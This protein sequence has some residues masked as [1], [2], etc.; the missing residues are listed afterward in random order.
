[1]GKNVRIKQILYGIAAS[2]VLVVLCWMSSNGKNEEK[3]TYFM[4]CFGDSILGQ[5]RNEYGVV[6][7]LE[8]K[9]QKSVFNGAFGGSHMSR[10]NSA[11]ELANMQDSLSMVALAEAIA[12][13]DFGPQQS[14]TFRGFGT[15]YFEEVIDGLKQIDFGE[16]EILLIEHGTNDYNYG[17]PLVNE[18]DPYDQYTFVGALRRTLALLKDN[19]PQLRIILVT[20]TYC[21]FPEWGYT[22][23]TYKPTG[24]TLLDYIEAEKQI[25]EEFNVEVIDHYHLFSAAEGDYL[26][27]T[28]DGLHPNDLGMEVIADS[29]FQYLQ[30][31]P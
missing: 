21:W 11:G 8:K 30:E 19:Y 14:A 26:H 24:A 5:V 29:I 15:E 1:M 9:V 4:V 6:G 2:A 20:P 16:A 18:E 22:C 23:E 12:Y 3:E 17:V 25:A 10:L 28:V 13:D 7:I 31:N 27:Y